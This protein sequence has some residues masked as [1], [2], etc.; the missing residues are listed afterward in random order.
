MRGFCIEVWV[1][2]D[3]GAGGLAWTLV[4]KSVRFHRAIAEMIGSEHFYHLTLDVIGVAA[5]VVFLRNGSCL[6]CIHLE[7]MKM[8]KLSENE[9]CPSALIY[10]YTIAWPPTFLNPTEEGMATFSLCLTVHPNSRV[11]HREEAEEL[12]WPMPIVHCIF[13]PIDHDPYD[14]FDVM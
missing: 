6:F 13:I 3:D 1:G 11:I 14:V 10:P 9:S 8:T 2:E 7:T 5:G 12:T 4:D